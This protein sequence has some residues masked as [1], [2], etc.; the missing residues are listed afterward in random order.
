LSYKIDPPRKK[1]KKGG[2]GGKEKKRAPWAIP[3]RRE[4]RKKFRS[5]PPIFAKGGEKKSNGY[6]GSRGGT[7]PF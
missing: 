3:V 7:I 1:K 2:K 5:N 4:K 6:F